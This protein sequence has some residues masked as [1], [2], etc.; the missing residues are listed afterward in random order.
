MPA[1]KS[2]EELKKIREEAL[3]SAPPLQ[4]TRDRIMHACT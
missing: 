3:E 1:I 4:D 2:L